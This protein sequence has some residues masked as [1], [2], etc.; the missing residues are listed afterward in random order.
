MTTTVKLLGNGQLPA[1]N[2]DL[3][4]VPASTSATIS[5]IILVNT[6]STT[7]TVNLYILPAGGTARKIIPSD[8]NLLARYQIEAGQKITL[9]AGDKIQGYTTTAS[10]VDYTISGVEFS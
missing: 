9:G 1:S 5:V 4:T 6:N 7:E 10:K 2:G 3:Y 8:Y